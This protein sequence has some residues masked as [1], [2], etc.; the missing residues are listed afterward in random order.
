MK[1]CAY[2]LYGEEIS[3]VKPGT[4][5]SERGFLGVTLKD[6]ALSDEF[7][8]HDDP[9]GYWVISGFSADNTQCS[10]STFGSQK[11]IYL[12]GLEKI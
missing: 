12:Y 2:I 1:S 8:G 6:F 3:G 5:T 10:A 9:N 11:E 7:S 4:V